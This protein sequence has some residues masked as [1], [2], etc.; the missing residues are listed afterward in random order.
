M[1][2]LI[3]LFRSGDV[4]DSIFVLLSGRL[5]SVEGK[6]IIDEFGRGDVLGMI[7]VIFF[8]YID[9][10]IF[11]WVLYTFSQPNYIIY[12]CK[13]SLCTQISLQ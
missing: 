7:E 1:S 12:Y 9:I 11:V 5:R 6:K 10:L 2:K 8:H 13:T 4:A 3:I